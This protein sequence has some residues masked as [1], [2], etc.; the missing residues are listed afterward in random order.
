MSRPGPVQ[1]IDPARVRTRR[2]QLGL[3]TATVARTTRVEVAVINRIESGSDQAGLSLGFI[4][5]LA[6]V[7]GTT[8]TDLLGAPP[9]APGPP[10]QPAPG[11][12]ATVGAVLAATAVWAPVVAVADTL[13]W[14]LHRTHVALDGLEATLDGAGQELVWLGEH[15]V[16]V[17]PSPGSGPAAAALEK[18]TLDEVG[19]NRLQALLLHRLVLGKNSPWRTR[20]ERMNGTR[21]IDL[22]LAQD[23]G[24]A[25]DTIALTAEARWD[26]CLDIGEAPS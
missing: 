24:G 20:N 6:R 1:L 18:S 17:A 2:R 9:P 26:L 12:V 23:L 5:D 13:G 10:E 14:T 4:D 22:G 11:D 8:S 16:K 19:L 7:L 25:A 21:L 3:D 15:D